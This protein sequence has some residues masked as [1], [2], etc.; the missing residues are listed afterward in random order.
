M[1]AG[2]VLTG[3]GSVT[4]VIGATYAERRRRNRRN[5]EDVGFMPWSLLTILGTMGALYAFA[6]A[7]KFA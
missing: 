7:V 3:V 4:L 1:Q 6:L 2:L 5:F